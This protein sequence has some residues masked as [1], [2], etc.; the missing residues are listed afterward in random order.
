MT[1]AFSIDPQAV[2]KRSE[3]IILHAGG[4]ICDWL[5][6]IERPGL[7]ERDEIIG[8]ALVMN[9]LLQIYFKAPIRIISE[10]ITDNRAEAY[11]SSKERLLFQREGGMLSEQE[12]TDLYWYIESLWALMWVGGLIDDLPFDEPVESFMGSLV[13]N[14]QHAE[15]GSKFHHKMQI[16]SYP[17]VFQMLDLYFRLHWYA[18]N[19]QLKRQS[20]DPVNLD[21]IMERR[22]ALEWV[23]RPGVD[24]DDVPLNT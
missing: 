13:P 17:E 6:I 5:P 9:A 11:L 18:R 23:M 2:K 12:L 10:W 22:K 19:G 20:T 8:R 21:I 3:A 24:W 1:P 14:L 4:Q 15:D 16:R 7:R